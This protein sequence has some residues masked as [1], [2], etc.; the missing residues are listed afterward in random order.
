M[1]EG[2]T[3][4]PRLFLEVFHA[5]KLF[6]PSFESKFVPNMGRGRV[7][8][9]FFCF[10]GGLGDRASFFWASNATESGGGVESMDIGV[11]WSEISALKSGNGGM[12]SSTSASMS[13]NFG[14]PG[15][16][17]IGKSGIVRESGKSSELAGKAG[18]A[19]VE[20]KSGN[21]GNIGEIGAESGN[22]GNI[23]EIRANGEIGAES[24]NAGNNGEFGAESGNVGN[25][26][27]IRAESGNAGNNGEF[28]AE[29]G[30]VGNN[31]KIGAKSGNAGNNGE[32]WAESGNAGNNGE[33]GADSGNGG[34]KVGP[35]WSGPS[36]PESIRLAFF[37][38]WVKS[39]WM[40][41]DWPTVLG[42]IE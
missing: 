11:E 16:R 39:G 33:V 35:E 4:I 26:G 10:W 29:S 24:G 6:L 18:I 17:V 20:A 3:S 7:E 23:G 1:L 14:G 36:L 38:R 2:F 13:L 32:I 12:S 25:N 8:T 5:V 37:F 19:E 40:I 27:K 9:T 42:R 22:A 15:E 30:N 34:K 31:G 41:R 28:G 21:A